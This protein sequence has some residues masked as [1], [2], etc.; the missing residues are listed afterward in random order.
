MTSG[1]QVVARSKFSE[2]GNFNI[3]I[4]DPNILFLIYSG[5]EPATSGS[6]V[7]ARSKF[8]KFIKLLSLVIVVIPDPNIYLLYFWPEPA[9][10]RSPGLAKSKFSKFSKAIKFNKC[11]DPRS[12][13]LL[14]LLLV[15]GDP[16]IY[17]I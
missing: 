3:G 17:L 6:T 14:N 5:P 7:V 12:Q 8:S 9:T 11:W 16:N 13:H 15:S 10:S 2:F 1:P 4:P